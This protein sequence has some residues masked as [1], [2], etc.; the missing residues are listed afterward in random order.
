MEVSYLVKGI[1][2]VYGRDEEDW[3]QERRQVLADSGSDDGSMK[4]ARL[5]GGVSHQSFGAF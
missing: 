4:D 5:G 3:L 1:A 2:E